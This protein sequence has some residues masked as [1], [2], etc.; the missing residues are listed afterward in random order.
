MSGS[1][2]DS[3]ALIE[4]PED[5]TPEKKH[6]QSGAEELT[7]CNKSRNDTRNTFSLNEVINLGIPHVCR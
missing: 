6:K 7:N 4:K 5:L 2:H 3:S 1:L